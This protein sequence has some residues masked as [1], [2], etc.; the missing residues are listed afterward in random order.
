MVDAMP[1]NQNE[2]A[3]IAL[4]SAVRAVV[5]ASPDELENVMGREDA[6]LERLIERGDLPEAL[7]G[8]WISEALGERAKKTVQPSTKPKG[9]AKR[10][11]SFY[12]AAAL[13]GKDVPEREW[14]VKGMVPDRQ[15]TL[16]MGDGGTG[17]SLLALQLAV[18]VAAGGSW[19][20][21]TAKEGRVIFMSAEDDDEELHRRLDDIL[22][23]G[24]HSYDDVRGLIMRS[25]AGEDALLAFDTKLALSKSELFHELERRATIERP[26]LIVLDTL[27]DIYPANEN[28]RA[29]VRQFVGILR[30]LAIARKCAV[31][32]LGHPSLTGMLSG[33]GTSGS[34][35]WNNS[36][37]SRLYLKRINDGDHE[38]DPDKRVLSTMKSNY[39]RAGGEILLTWTDGA[40]VADREPTGMEI[41]SATAR[42]E[43]VFLW[44]L[45]EFTQQGR[46]V[47]ASPGPTYAPSQ[48]AGHPKS[49]A[50]T[51]RAFRSAMDALFDRSEIVVAEHGTGAKKRSH[52]AR[53]QAG[54]NDD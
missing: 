3:L 52:I 38:P 40:F 31:L 6:R 10:E 11:S 27:A 24:G 45:D 42:A 43:R 19:I 46:Y 32:V 49:E 7:R 4:S 50:I 17:K 30:S 16:M 53:K 39:G 14:I 22:R 5:N 44:L 33:S 13:S 21:R 28:D 35:A 26:S 2:E 15:V 37:R 29:K 25:L 34:T 1:A 54:G 51:K 36:V 12:S 20:E 23:A 9:K 47:S 41:A 48:F 18:A 8:Q